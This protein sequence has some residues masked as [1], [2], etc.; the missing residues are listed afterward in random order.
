MVDI[1][2]KHEYYSIRFKEKEKR[3]NKRDDKLEVVRAEAGIRDTSN[4]LDLVKEARRTRDS[5]NKNNPNIAKDHQTI[6]DFNLYHMPDVAIKLSNEQ[7]AKLRRHPDIRWVVKSQLRT[8]KAESV[9]WGITR[10]GGGAN[11]DNTK[12]HRGYGVRVAVIDTGIDF[13]HVDLK[14]NYKGGV[15]FIP[16]NSSPLADDKPHYHGTHVSGTIAAAINN[17]GVV[18]VAPEAWLHAVK[19]LGANGGSVGESVTEGIVWANENNMDVLSMS[20]GGFGFTQAES[21]AVHTAYTSNRFVSCAA[22]NENINGNP[23]GPGQPLIE[24]PA[25]LAGSWAIA[26]VDDTDTVADFSNYGP[27]GYVD[28]SCPGVNVISD[29]NGGGTQSLNGTSMATPHASGIFALGLSNYRF[30]PCD[31]NVYDPKLTKISHIVGAMI[32]SCDTL[33]QTS[34]GVQNAHYGFGMPQISTMLQMLNGNT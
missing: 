6:T 21:D 19:V 3:Q 27:V 15:S 14:P 25:G 11:V 4:V 23:N 1:D 30:T 28:F 24:Y 20:L 13:N 10:V 2:P 26:A 17:T 7:A 9:P 16:G 5:E 22:G 12:Y 32:A 34:S 8:A 33:G 29:M 31:T 18:G